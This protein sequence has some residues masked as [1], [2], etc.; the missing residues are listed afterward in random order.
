MKIFDGVEVGSTPQS[1]PGRGH[2]WLSVVMLIVSSFINAEKCRQERIAGDGGGLGTL[3]QVMAQAGLKIP[4]LPEMLAE[5]MG[6]EEEAKIAASMIANA[7]DPLSLLQQFAK[8]FGAD[9][10]AATTTAPDRTGA[11]GVPT[12]PTHSE[13]APPP[14]ASQMTGP[15]SPQADRLPVPAGP[16][17]SREPSPTDLSW[18]H[19]DFFR[20]AQEAVRAAD[21]AGVPVSTGDCTPRPK[22]RPEF[23]EPPE[24]AV[25]ASPSPSRPAHAP[26]RPSLVAVV[27][28]QLDALRRRMGAYEAELNIRLS[29]A[30][31]ELAALRDDCRQRPRPSLV[32]VPPP[33]ADVGEPQTPAA[34]PVEEVECALESTEADGTQ[35]Q[36]TPCALVDDATSTADTATTPEERPQ[37]VDTATPAESTVGELAPSATDDE[38]SRAIELIA[39]FGSEVDTRYQHDLARI[40]SVEEEA[41]VLRAVV[42]GEALEPAAERAS[43]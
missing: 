24:A 34:D 41:R 30:E 4:G 29:R 38:V 26:P 9:A 25:A 2:T 33:A 28:R 35:L 12:S 27:E 42:R 7:P 31:A 39:E 3:D 32:V 5:L 13:S 15:S 16:G 22:F 37:A 6:N 21:A 18:E 23:A 19:P 10:T 11:P 1:K 43:S 36:P 14:R 17:A 40:R 8:R 20:R